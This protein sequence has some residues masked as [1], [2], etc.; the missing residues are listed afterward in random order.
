[1]EHVWTV[2]SSRLPKYHSSAQLQSSHTFQLAL[3][4]HFVNEAQGLCHVEIYTIVLYRD[5]L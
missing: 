5:H 1:M 2:G 4:L 3:H